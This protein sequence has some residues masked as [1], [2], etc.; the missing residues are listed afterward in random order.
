MAIPQLLTTGE[1]ARAL[2]VSVSCLEAW[3]IKGRGPRF[4]K[5]GRLVKYADI[6]LEEFL[7]AGVR[8]ER[9]ALPE[10]NQAA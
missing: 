3:R 9:Q 4:R 10:D 1:A 5:V 7:S 8:G 6:D 2:G